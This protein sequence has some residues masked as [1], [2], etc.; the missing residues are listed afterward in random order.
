MHI[1][2]LWYIRFICQRQTP[3][4]FTPTLLIFRPAY[5]YMI[6]PVAL[7]LLPPLVRFRFE[8]ELS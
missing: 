8:Q 3:D 5:A 2:F 1:R 4:E 6:V 7:L